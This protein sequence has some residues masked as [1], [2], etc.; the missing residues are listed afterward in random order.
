MFTQKTDAANR[1]YKALGTINARH[2]E[3]VLIGRACAAGM[4]TCIALALIIGG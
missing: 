3:R 1:H 4:L 2:I